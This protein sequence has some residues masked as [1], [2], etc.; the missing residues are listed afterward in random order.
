M[1]TRF[2]VKRFLAFSFAGFLS[3][4]SFNNCTVSKPTHLDPGPALSQSETSNRPPKVGLD[5]PLPPG[6][7]SGD[8]CEDQLIQLFAAGYHTFLKTNCAF[9]HNTG[10]GKGRFATDDVLT[11][12][13]DFKTIGYSA[14][15]DKA[16][17]SSHNPPYTGPQHVQDVNDNRLAW[18]QGLNEYGK[19]K[20][21][22]IGM[23]QDPD[24][25]IT[26]ITKAVPIPTMNFDEEKTIA[27]NLQ[28]DLSVYENRISSLPAIP[29]GRISV[30]ISRRQTSGGE[31]YYRIRSPNLIGNTVDTQI[32]GLHFF[33][34]GRLLKY[35]TTFNYVDIGIRA[36]SSNTAASLI[37]AGSLV[38]AGVFSDADTLSLALEELNPTTLPPPPPPLGIQFSG[39][40][41]MTHLGE[42]GYIDI[43][44]DLSAD[45]LDL[46]MAEV[47]ATSE[48]LCGQDDGEKEILVN[49]TDCLPEVY[50]HLCPS[51][52]CSVSDMNFKRARSTTGATYNRFDWDYKF[53]STTLMF[54][55]MERQ[56]T[57]RIHLSDDRRKETNRILTVKLTSLSPNLEVGSAQTVRI[58]I[59]KIDNP[60]PTVGVPT[61]TE[62]MDPNTGILGVNCYKCHNSSKLE[63]GYDMS[64]YALMIQRQILVPGSTD[65]KMFRRM[66]ANDPNYENLQPM[67]LDGFLDEAYIRLVEKWILDGAKNN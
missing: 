6:Q 40:T 61:F 67:P 42:V 45:P 19:C 41:I 58:L 66:N 62:L 26:L 50:T 34:N 55:G 2:S 64:N 30:R 51:G 21:I 20:G 9:C 56:K 44:V 59:P 43:P 18:T 23:V 53:P 3:L 65:S 15:S 35:P 1:I 33:L 60:L 54:S 47:S 13:A 37:S 31:S 8:I 4:F 11:A 49:S 39:P 5:A 48:A 10:P 25:L 17:S 38:A 24:A 27:W 52:T 32:K 28:G 7:F 29:G 57:I 36:A 12:Y 46:N 63:G 16:T 22:D 14:I